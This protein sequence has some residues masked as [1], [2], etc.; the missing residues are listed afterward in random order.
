VANGT[1]EKELIAGHQKTTY[2]QWIQR[3]GLPVVHG[4]GVEDV[5]QL[6][7][8]HWSRL[9]GK[10]GFIHLYGMEG[11]T[12][13][14][15]AQIPPGE[16]LEP[17]HHL[18]EEVICIL[19]GNGATEIW[20]EGG[21]KRIF[22]WGKGS[23]FS[24][25]V[26]SWHRLLNGGREPVLFLAVTNAPLIMDIFHNT[27]FVLNCPYA[28]TDRYSGQE[29]YFSVGNKR[30]ELGRQ[31][32]WETNFIPDVLSASLGE[33]D[34]KGAGVQLTQFELSGNALIG[35][36][37]Q[38]PAGRY[39]K[40][41]YHGPGA[42]LLGLQSSGYVLLWPKE[43]G[44]RPY[45]SG[46][47]D[48]VVEVKWREGSV[49][50]PPNDW[51]HQHFNTGSQPARHLALRYGSRL[52]HLGFKVA[53]RIMTQGKDE[54]PYTSVRK[55]GTLIEYEDEDPEIRRRYDEELKR[56]GVTSAMPEIRPSPSDSH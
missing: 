1:R 12:G 38:W 20:Q 45:E 39:H 4:Y 36:V 26:N 47:S 19:E 6:E 34:I 56:T 13:M 54:E 2:G 15:V 29:K 40:A 37:A 48:Q 44:I 32:I 52:F 28:F 3:E 41:H 10:W 9:G 8:A 21:A 30:Y 46:N 53:G 17:E 27:D 31:H 5:R 55:G 24:P 18:Y 50:C 16:A 25:P 11:F 35:H 23:L 33:R 22:E 14:Y 51:F 7:M 43:V 42:I 49:Y